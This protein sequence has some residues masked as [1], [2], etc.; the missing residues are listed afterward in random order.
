MI[1]K[2]LQHGFVQAR[3]NKRMVAVYYLANLLFGLLL[4]LPLRAILSDF[5][6]NSLMA[7]RLAGPLDMDFLFEFF[8]H[9]NE[10]VSVFSGM[11]LV[12]PLVYWFFL[13]FLSGGA[14]AVFAHGDK[15]HPTMFWGSAAKYF[16]RFCRLALWSVLFLAV[17]IAAYLSIIGIERLLLGSDPYQN[18]SYWKGWINL[19]LR[20]FLVL[21]FGLA[22]DYGRIYT[23]L[24]D[25]RNMRAALKHGIKFAFGNFLQTFGLAFMLLII[26]AVLLVI[27]NPIANSLS[28]PHWLIVIMLFFVQQ[29][30]MVFRMLLRLT[31][32]ASQLHLYQQLAAEPVPAT[33]TS[34]SDLTMGDLGVAT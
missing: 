14:L 6:G 34:T 7:A 10:A 25:E 31:S 32:Y 26:G 27:Y 21:L 9:K 17:L 28:A 2:S 29:L 3:S 19:G 24:T 20:S 33:A 15:Y 11:S 23:V 12:V 18:L 16:G 8:K 4:M 30:Y 13:L 5:V 1:L 22:L